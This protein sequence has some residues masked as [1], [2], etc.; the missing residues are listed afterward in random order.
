M[1]LPAVQRE[2]REGEIKLSD[3]RNPGSVLSGARCSLSVLLFLL[4]WTIRCQADPGVTAYASS[5][6]EGRGAEYVLDAGGPST[7]WYAGSNEMPQWVALD[8]GKTY[9]INK[10]RWKKIPSHPYPR[11]YAVEI[12]DSDPDHEG[13]GA[14]ERIGHVTGNT[15]EYE[16]VVEFPAVSTRFIRLLVTSVGGRNGKE[17]GGRLSIGDLAVGFADPASA[18][19]GLSAEP[20]EGGILLSWHTPG[21]V[22]RRILGYEIYRS[23]TNGDGFF[24][25]TPAGPVRGGMYLDERVAPGRRYRYRLAARFKGGW[26]GRPS[27]IA[28][29]TAPREAGSWNA[30][31]RLK[32]VS[33]Y[34]IGR[35]GCVD[36]L[37]ERTFTEGLM[38]C[39]LFFA[40]NRQ[41]YLCYPTLRS[42]E[43][44]FIRPRYVDCNYVKN[45][46][47][48]GT[49]RPITG[50]NLPRKVTL[51]NKS[52][53]GYTVEFDYGGGKKMTLY[54]SLLSPAVVVK[55][56]DI[57]VRLFDEMETFGVGGPQYTA[58]VSG[59]G[60]RTGSFNS[61]RIIKPK[62]SEPW[63]LVWFHG[64]KGWDTFDVP[65]LVVFQHRPAS[66]ARSTRSLEAMFEGVPCGYVALMPL[67]GMEKVFG[68]AQWRNELPG[69]VASRCR[70]WARMV[71]SIPIACDESYTVDRQAK[72]VTVHQDYKFLDVQDEWGT[73]Q[74]HVSPIPPVVGL[75]RRCGYPVVFGE[76]VRSLSYQTPFGPLYGAV[77]SDSVEWTMPAPFDAAASSWPV[78]SKIRDKKMAA[79]ARRLFPLE[80]FMWVSGV[81]IQSAMEKLASRGI[82]MGTS[83][84][85][86]LEPSYIF[87]RLMSAGAREEVAGATRQLFE[88]GALSAK[89]MKL[90]ADS[91][92][93]RRVYVDGWIARDEGVGYGAALEAAR[94]L[95]GVELCSRARGNG[96]LP[97]RHW[98]SIVSRLQPLVISSDWAMQG[99]SY[100]AISGIPRHGSGFWLKLSDCVEI[101]EALVA[102]AALAE[103]AGCEVEFRRGIYLAAKLQAL[104]SLYFGY[105]E[106]AAAYKPWFAEDG[107]GQP[108][109]ARAVID[110]ISGAFGAQSWDTHANARLLGRTPSSAVAH[111]YAGFLRGRLAKCISARDG[112]SI[113]SG[114]LLLRWLLFE[115]D[116]SRL[117]RWIPHMRTDGRN[118]DDAP[119][120]A[121]AALAPP[122]VAGATADPDLA[123]DDAVGP[124][125][126]GTELSYGKMMTRSLRIADGE[127]VWSLG[128]RDASSDE[129]AERV[130]LKNEKGVRTLTFSI[131]RDKPAASWPR[132]HPG[133]GG[134]A[135]GLTTRCNIA[136]TLGE[137]SEG[138]YYLLVNLLYLPEDYPLIYRVVLAGSAQMVRCPEGRPGV[139]RPVELVFPLAGENLKA[140]T[141]RISL[142]VCGGCRGVE[143]DAV[144]MVLTRP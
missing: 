41:P 5:A 32:G 107:A 143:Y 15:D 111:F 88:E 52:W 132:F 21:K 28:D 128:E 80:R 101:Y 133:D 54:A 16:N 13:A 23:D 118:R 96:E 50:S 56:D 73:P 136:F 51:L 45:P 91:F 70:R 125:Q 135:G 61:R 44:I 47:C 81:P 6:A 90:R 31:V 36:Y 67:F 89:L 134:D 63:M 19:V 82:G 94:I 9:K 116:A 103:R 38:S 57:G 121:A 127:E 99:P 10:L 113:Y 109:E 129:F 83:I 86:E 138:T 126:G 117:W 60:T 130:S 59:G 3:R 7:A 79:E 26:L 29:A 104:I 74:K 137:K 12:T 4:L 49:V 1:S 58:F 108:D 95:K 112:S 42:R 141:N 106:Y 76:G 92:S 27:E 115:R 35:F 14:W 40:R 102:Y 2:H 18:D 8:L 114:D 72:T 48:F 43:E 75:A 110:F 131:G 97:K 34:S 85:A 65:W 119:V 39:S 30:S 87:L 17:G 144:R 93:P 77:D 123:V 20:N 140:G 105:Q 46:L 142:E 24:L 71:R 62:M 122:D 64:R 11:D 22:A 55:V 69:A 66:V 124:P 98:T 68:N 53:V 37:R 25:L 139:R 33:D 84:F 78:D 100:A 120:Y